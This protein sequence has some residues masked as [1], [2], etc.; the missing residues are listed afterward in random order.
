MST[1]RKGLLPIYLGNLFEYYDY[2]LYG[3]LFP[4]IKEYFFP[5]AATP[6]LGLVIY[7]VGFFMRPLGALV[8][9]YIGDHY[10]RRIA[11]ILSTGGMTLSCLLMVV[12]P[13]YKD[14]GV[15]CIVFL[16]LSRVLQGLSVGGEYAGSIVLGGEVSKA[17]HRHKVAGLIGSSTLVG[18]LLA[19]ICVALYNLYSHIVSWQFL[20]VIGILFGGITFLIRSR[21]IE[22]LDMQKASKGREY[23]STLKRHPGNVLTGMFP[24]ALTGVNTGLTT[25]FVMVYLS[26]PKVG[27]FLYYAPVTLLITNLSVQIAGALAFGRLIRSPTRSL[28]GL[29]CVVFSLAMGA[30]VGGILNQNS[31]L[32]LGGSVV[33]SF[34]TGV[35]WGLANYCVFKL[36]PSHIRY[37]GVALSDSLA[38]TLFAGFAPLLFVKLFMS[39]TSTLAISFPYFVFI[40]LYYL[41]LR[42]IFHKISSLK[43]SRARAEV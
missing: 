39:F 23:L 25:T 11:L 28:A 24:L 26:T 42:N 15:L 37:T 36:F 7:G 18:C 4:Q 33:F 14:I 1:R 34:A 20:Y 19:A 16:I 43:L 38:R 2:A 10:G 30:M 5:A 35:G 13:G 21:L 3:Y 32:L 40:A 12:A 41:A 8:F 6:T 29:V 27:S 31:W 22:S 17:S 9:G